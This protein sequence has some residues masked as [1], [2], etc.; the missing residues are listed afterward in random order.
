MLTH[1][2]LVLLLIALLACPADAQLIG[3][4]GAGVASSVTSFSQT[5]SGAWSFTVPG[6]AKSVQIILCGGGGGGGGGGSTTGGG[7]GGGGGACIN[8]ILL[9]VAG[10][11]ISGSVGAGGAGGIGNNG[12]TSTAGG[13]TR[14]ATAW[15]GRRRRR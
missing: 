10:V 6:S 3:G 8:Q 2:C 12:A 4:S 11:A 7:G 15:R 14:A 1:L 13:N 5:T 9:N